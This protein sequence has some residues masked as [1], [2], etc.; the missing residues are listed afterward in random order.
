MKKIIFMLRSNIFFLLLPAFIL[1][2]C[3]TGVSK[4]L[5]IAEDKRETPE[6]NVSDTES[7][8]PSFSPD[9]DNG[10]DADPV[11]PE[12]A[13]FIDDT[14]KTSMQRDGDYLYSYFD[15]RL[16]RTHGETGETT[17]LYQ[18][19][20]LLFGDYFYYIDT[21]EAE[22]SLMRLSLREKPDFQKL[23]AWS[24]YPAETEMIEKDEEIAFRDSDSLFSSMK[25]L[26]AGA[27]FT[28]ISAR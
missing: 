7:F 23:Q 28:E 24:L 27:E 8:G 13:P 1:T 21:V 11:F 4:T 6:T 10:F 9:V 20:Y 18:T 12:T 16:M 25:L 26:R 5:D 22:H 15:G 3:G 17:L 19:S 14:G 2:G